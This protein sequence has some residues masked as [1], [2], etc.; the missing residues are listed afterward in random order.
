[1]IENK[2]KE[3]CTGCEAC[4]NICPQNAIIMVENNEGFKFPSID[5]NKC[6]KCGLCIRKCPKIHPN[7]NN[8]N[9]PE[10]YAYMSDD[11]NRLKSSS[12]GAFFTLANHFINNNDFVAGAVFDDKWNVKHIV[13]DKLED[14]E[15]MRDSKYTQS[16]IN[17]CYKTIKDILTTNK[18]VLFSGTP[19]QIAGLKAYLGKNYDNL[20]CVDIICH[21]V[22]SPKIFRKY[23]S[24]K[25]N[26]DEIE[27]IKFRDKTQNGWGAGLTIKTKN[28]L[29]YE[30]STTNIFYQLFWT[31]IMLRDSCTDCKFNK[32]PRQGDITI[33]DYW[34]LDDKYNDKLGTSVVLINN[35]HGEYLLNI[36]TQNKKLLKKVEFSSTYKSNRNIIES[37]KCNITKR[38]QF[39]KNIDTMSI[40]E[41]YFSTFKNGAD[42][43][44]LNF[45]SAGNYGAILTCF[46]TQCMLEKLGQNAKVINYIPEIGQNYQNSF[47]KKFADNYLNLSEPVENYDDF[48]NLN[49]NC[50]TF[51]VGPDQVFNYNITRTHHTNTSENIY[52]L[53]FVKSGNKKISYAPS[54]GEPH[55]NGN[56]KEKQFFDYYIKK[57]DAISVRE[58][59]GTK[60]LNDDFNVK[61]Q[62]L[63]DGAFHI[64]QSMLEQMT[65]TYKTEEKYIAVFVFG[66]YK[67]EKWYKD[68]IKNI[69]DK[70]KI[71]VKEFSGSTV[72][73][74]L[75]YIKNAQFVAA[76]SYHAIVFS[77][78]FNVPFVQIKTDLLA[79]SRF[80][81][82]FNIFNIEDN[83]INRYDLNYD[84]NNI[85]INR[86]W[87]NINS[88][89]KLYVEQAEEW[90]ANAIK[91]PVAKNIEPDITHIL[92]SE[93]LKNNTS[94]NPKPTIYQTV[95]YYFYKIMIIF[96]FGNLKNNYKMRK[97]KL[98]CFF[99][100]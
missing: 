24:E 44:I 26:L 18:K 11:I 59:A 63:I 52:L 15:K 45:W 97:S 67:N 3:N 46:G 36:L 42:C 57:F 88:K 35:K 95:K 5:I 79:Q 64:P 37:S 54:F 51:I 28:Q 25:F 73:E 56:E 93:I 39:Y 86:D 94:G 98:S 100:K 30:D 68:I 49:E 87:D 70:L 84:Y 9:T 96:T 61:A 17:K 89:I 2:L 33:G 71:P 76:G 77:I 72:E 19:C 74:W 12:G 83:T 85:L 65:E 60:I 20:Y 10:A 6:T 50:N 78:I 58:D 48:I 16:S 32:V 69:Q 47:C 31:N 34:G 82:L 55:F 43:M 99:K 91:T 29:F 21:G 66:I 53:D 92:K 27:K 90:M 40:E 4:F 62:R 14:V 13:S 23:L 22:N 75:A 81:T 7:Y 80:E 8:D 41:N 38:S 1:M